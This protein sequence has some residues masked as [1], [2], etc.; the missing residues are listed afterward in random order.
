M[1]H[2]KS[3]ELEAATTPEEKLDLI[4]YYLERMDRRDRMRMWGSAVHSLLALVPMLFFAW[5]TWYLYAHFD[6]I[7][8]MMMRQTAQKAA[9]STGQ[10]Y[11]DVMKQIRET[12][13]MGTEQ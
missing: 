13:G 11:D 5:S 12:F 8:G 3:T 4:A 6:D 9:T 7:M 2:R 10:S 1:P